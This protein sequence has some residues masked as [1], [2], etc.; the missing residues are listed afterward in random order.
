MPHGKTPWTRGLHEDDAEESVMSGISYGETGDLDLVE[1]AA[2]A[3]V[4]PERESG[5]EAGLCVRPINRRCAACA[6]C[7]CFILGSPCRTPTR[8]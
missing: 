4:A 6:P 8:S 5:R 3:V 7:K 1:G 2:A